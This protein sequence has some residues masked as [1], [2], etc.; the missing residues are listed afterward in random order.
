MSQRE[1]KRRAIGMIVPSSNRV[2]ERVA[3]RMLATHPDID[4]CVARVP[5]GG[6]VEGDACPRYRLETFDAAAALLADAGV[7]VMCWNATRGAI[8]GFAPDRELCQ[9]IEHRTGIAAVTTAIA[10]LELLAKRGGE[11]IG[12]ITQGDESEAAEVSQRFRS[13]GVDVAAQSW[14]GIVHNLDAAR[15]DPDELLARIDDLATRSSLDTVVVWSTNLP[16]FA[17]RLGAPPAW[18]V[19]VLDSAEI[20]VQVALD[21]LNRRHI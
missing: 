1:H 6:I 21:S 13:E 20:G 11:R 10:T 17:A 8:L 3:T 12:F 14:L 7:D 18:S 9:R 4:L 19:E 5:Y 2:V 15:F 16:G